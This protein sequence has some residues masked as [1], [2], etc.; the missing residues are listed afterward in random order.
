MFPATIEEYLRPR[1]AAE[2][3]AAL[4]RFESGEAMCIA[5]GQSLM[6]AIKSR[7]IRPRCLVD[8][9][10]VAELQGITADGALVIGAMTRYVDI[11]HATL[12]VACAALRDAAQHVGD[13]QVRNRGTI[14]G[15]VCWNY[16]AA[17]MPAVVLGLGG[18]LQLIDARGSVRRLAVDDFLLGPLETA[19]AEDEILVCIRFEP[20]PGRGGSAYRKWGLVTDALPVLGVCI[21]LAL[22]GAGACS[23]ARIALA[24]LAGGAQRAPAGE[25]ALLGSRGDGE[26]VA[27]ALEAIVDT[28]ETH[29]D[30]WADAQY[31]RQLIRTI[32]AEVAATAFARARGE[33]P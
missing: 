27:R 14:G 1:S 33:T 30:Q 21:R 9:Q 31:R 15:S 2:A 16:V 18:E 6:Q 32:G 4:A 17:C 12:P 3:A 19:R 11:A 29:D 26:S 13:R 8:L 7:M 24:G 28:V 23:S 5:G 10:D 20:I 22:D 25:Q